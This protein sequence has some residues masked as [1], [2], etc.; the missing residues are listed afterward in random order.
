MTNN[1]IHP[2]RISFFGTGCRVWVGKFNE[3]EWENMNSAAG[4]VKLPLTS[5]LFSPAFYSRLNNPAISSIADLGNSLKISGLLD[6]NHSIIQIQVYRKRRRNIN[7]SEI[8]RPTTLFPIYNMNMRS[9]AVEIDNRMLFIVEKEIGLFFKFAVVAQSFI[10]DKL[11][12][13]FT[14]LKTVGGENFD[15]LTNLY[16]DGRLLIPASG[17]SLIC[18]QYALAGKD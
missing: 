5:A 11:L 10:L 16:Y 18:G 15:M 7:F 2:V 9:M 12:F 1:E 3:T 4:K 13:E 6:S 8:V 14:G 17:N